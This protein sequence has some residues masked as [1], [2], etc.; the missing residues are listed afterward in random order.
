MLARWMMRKIYSKWCEDGWTGVSEVGEDGASNFSLGMVEAGNATMQNSDSRFSAHGIPMT[1]LDASL[2]RRII[3]WIVRNVLQDF[4][5]NIVLT[6]DAKFLSCF[7]VFRPNTPYC[8]CVGGRYV[9]RGRSR[10][11][12]P[13][14]WVLRRVGVSRRGCTF[15]RTQA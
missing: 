1:I 14:R 7:V 10:D 8:L 6:S 13:L 15:P 12:V 3:C 9:V 4:R 5:I 11:S 2:N